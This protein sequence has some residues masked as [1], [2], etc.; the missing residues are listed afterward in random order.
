MSTSNIQHGV[1]EYQLNHI[2]NLMDVYCHP[3]TSGGMEIP[4]FEKQQSLLH[5]SQ[6]ILVVKILAPQ[7]VVAYH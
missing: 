3:F 7:R 4:I 2:Y 1:N 6:I 5:W